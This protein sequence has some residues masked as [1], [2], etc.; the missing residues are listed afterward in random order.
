MNRAK[1]NGFT[2]IELM[3]VV[4][5]IGILASIAVPAYQD[6]ITRAKLA[7]V[8][9][10]STGIKQAIADY[11]AH[12]GEMPKDNQTLF[13]GKPESMQGKTV[14]AMTVENGAIHV[15]ISLS[16]QTQKNDIVSVRPVL[17]KQTSGSE[18][19]SDYIFWVYGNC[20]IPDATQLEVL[21]TNKTTLTNDNWIKC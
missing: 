16:A 6:Y 17:L 7:E 21:G 15:S 18:N 4:S 13:L 12:H 20:K 19:P 9:E 11:Y 2:L 14:K 10:M 1:Q 3:V 5:I 8:F